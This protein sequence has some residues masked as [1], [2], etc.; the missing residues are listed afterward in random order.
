MSEYDYNGYGND[1]KEL[2]KRN[3]FVA[4]KLG[5]ALLITVCIVMKKDGGSFMGYAFTLVAT[6]I[7]TSLTCIYE[8]AGNRKIFFAAET[9]ALLASVILLGGEL[10]FMLPLVISDAVFG[11]KMSPYL[12]VASLI[13][14]I[15]APDKFTYIMLCLF[16]SA[17]YYQHHAII[18]KY[19]QSAEDYEQ[20]EMKLKNSIETNAL[21]FKNEIR[22]TSLHYENI[23]LQDKTRLSQE[24]HDKLGHRINGSIYQLEAC[25]A[26]ASVD[27]RKADEILNRVNNSLR[28]G[29]DEIRALLRRERPDSRRMALLQLNS[30]CEECRA[31]YGIEAVLNI[32][33]DS[34]RI[35]DRMWSVIFD[36][37]CEAVTNALKYS[38]C[39]RIDIEINVLNKMLRCCV[40]DN[41][42]GCGLIHDGMGIRGMKQRIGQLG[43]TVD[44]SGNDGFRIN[45]LIPVN[46]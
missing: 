21:E 5:Y 22:R 37:C 8:I 46:S 24:L 45:M 34:G 26:I 30:L 6:A 20:R 28:E 11:F 38:Q 13:G 7:C 3:Y 19:R 17:I 40:S 42:K 32:S 10:I 36:N 44:I 27:P 12:L 18:L 35:D 2:W 1:L 41:G 39:S 31:Q 25:R 14:I 23:M 16:T 9:A 15:Y 4:V 29:M 43:G 33:G